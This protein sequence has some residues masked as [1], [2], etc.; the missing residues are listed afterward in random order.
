MFRLFRKYVPVCQVTEIPEGKLKA[1]EVGG[2]PVILGRVAGKV[3]A[4][5]DRCPHQQNPLHDGAVRGSVVTCP[6][7]SMSFDLATGKVVEDRGFQ[8]VPGLCRIP[9]TI[10]GGKV[11][12]VV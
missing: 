8:G 4:A 1:V 5:E 7:H 11:C 3:L 9:V 2:T 6:F 10:R 12:L